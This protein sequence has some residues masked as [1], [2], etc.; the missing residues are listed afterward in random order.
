MVF[1]LAGLFGLDLKLILS[2]S[3]RRRVS[4]SFLSLPIFSSSPV[5]RL[6]KMMRPLSSRRIWPPN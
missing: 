1:M 2:T 5:V 6:L 4:S 3:A